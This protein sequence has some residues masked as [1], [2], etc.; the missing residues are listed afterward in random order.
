MGFGPVVIVL[1]VSPSIESVRFPGITG[2]GEMMFR[3]MRFALLP[4]S[5]NDCSTGTGSLPFR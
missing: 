3:K 2:M 5:Q 4:S 1:A